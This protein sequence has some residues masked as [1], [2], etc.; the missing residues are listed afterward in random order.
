MSYSIAYY[1]K[2]SWNQEDESTRE[3]IQVAP[4]MAEGGTVR[5]EPV[6]NDE[7]EFVTLKPA[8]ITDCE[9]NITYN[10]SKF[11]YDHIDSELGIKWLYGKTGKEVKDR[12]EQAIQNLGI[13]KET[14]PFWVIN[15]DYTFGQFFGNKKEIPGA[16]TEEDIKEFITTD[17]DDEKNADLRDILVSLEILQ[18]GGAYWK[19]TPGNAG[20]ALMRIMTWII[21]N[22]DGV[23]NGD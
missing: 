1:T 11:Y 19:A 18:D 23:F 17:W 10:Y 14:E 21:Q 9:I 5:A 3:L 20:H 22:P 7:G 4:F 13:N 15:N 12:L 6:Y 8:T 16:Y 2:D